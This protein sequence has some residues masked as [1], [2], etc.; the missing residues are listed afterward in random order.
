MMQ[1]N[2][3]VSTVCCALFFGLFLGG[4]ANKS[5]NQRQ[6]WV[7][8]STNYGDFMSKQA[9]S[10]HTNNFVE[11]PGNTASYGSMQGG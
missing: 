9:A 11:E 2:H 3:F 10:Q 8:R 7:N 1:A 4:C 6:L 5:G